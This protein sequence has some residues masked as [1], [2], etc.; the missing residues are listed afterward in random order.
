MRTAGAPETSISV[1]LPARARR[2]A[3]TLALPSVHPQTVLNLFIF[4]YRKGAEKASLFDMHLK[5]CSP[6]ASSR[7][8]AL[9][10][11]TSEPERER[12]RE[13]DAIPGQ[14][15]ALGDA[16][17]LILSICKISILRPR[18]YGLWKCP[19]KAI[20]VAG[21]T[22][23]SGHPIKAKQKPTNQISTGPVQG[24]VP[25]SARSEISPL[26]CCPGLKEENT[27][28]MLK[29]KTT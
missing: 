10:G 12:E 8:G 19:N 11:R 23:V 14:A 6:G 16:Q 3:P 28:K 25:V 21:T 13:P 15:T 26:T 29:D 4:V 27:N 20:Q 5:A 22:N 18:P 7:G 1:T 17:G 24:L 9:G 2:A